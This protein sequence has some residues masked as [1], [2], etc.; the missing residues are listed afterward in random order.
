MIWTD[1]ETCGL[2]PE[3]SPVL[4]VGFIITD[5]D[6]IEIDR[7]DIRLWDSPMYDNTFEYMLRNPDESGADYVLKMHDKNGLWKACQEDGFTIKEA[8][9]QIDDWLGSHGIQ[10][11]SLCGSS[12][13]FDRT[14]INY[15][16]P[17]VGER[18]HYRVLDV[19]SYKVWLSAK[20]PAHYADLEKNSL[21]RETHRALPD[22]EDTI[23]EFKFYTEN[24]VGLLDGTS[25]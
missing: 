13:D 17:K 19:T 16:F 14:F 23:A 11:E 9:Q 21:K 2:K 8:E 3:E 4:E 1:I 15:W 24:F 6:F 10:G 5:L 20:Y 7:W 25:E 18:F 12:V 22:I